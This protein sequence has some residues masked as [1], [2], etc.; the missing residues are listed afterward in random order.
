METVAAILFAIAAVGGLTLAAMHLRTNQPKLSVA[1]LH[2]LFAASGLVVLLIAV[3][4]NGGFGLE[5]TALVIFLAAALGGFALISMHLRG[6]ALS[7]PLVLV[8]GLVAVSA[9]VILLIGLVA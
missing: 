8:H 7:T 3:I 2:G 4:G 1:L 5:G 9:F 6:K